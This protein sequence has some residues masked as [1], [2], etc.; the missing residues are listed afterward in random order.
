MRLFRPDWTIRRGSGDF[1]VIN[2]VRLRYRIEGTGPDLV[3]VHGVGGRLEAWDG[4]VGLLRHRFRIIRSDLRGHGDSDKPPGP[5]ELNDF[6]VDLVGLLDRLDIATCRLAGFSLGGL[7][8]Q[9]F[10]LVWPDRLERLVLLSTVAGRTVEEKERVLKRLE[11]V[12]G[13]MP[14]AHF[15]NSVERWFTDEFRA[16]NPDIIARYAERS[17]SNDLQAYAAAYRV[18]AMSDVADRLHE[19]RVPTL[20]VTGEN[21][22][23]SNTRMA[24]LMHDRIAAASFHIFPH[25]RHSILIEAPEQVAAVMEAFLSDATLA[26]HLK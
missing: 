5:Y 17:R 21:D 3:L 15:E 2:G 24:R 16:A 9:G 22:I 13:G 11:I 26:Q 20:V 1:Q 4:V 10:A 14:E 7:V 18:L 19:I 25:L 6:V 8:V 12:S 23:G